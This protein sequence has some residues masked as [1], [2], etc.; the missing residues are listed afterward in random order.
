MHIAHNAH[1]PSFW[2]S[3][4]PLILV[5]GIVVW[6]NLRPQKVS[7]ARLFLTPVL[8]VLI[9]AMVVWGNQFTSAA[10]PGAIAVAII[11]G[12]LVGIPVGLLRGK[13]TTV[14]P[15]E[16]HHVMIL[17][18]SW[19]T[20]AIYLAAFGVRY[21]ARAAFPPTSSIGSAIGD[22]A[23]AFAGSTIV[24]AYSVIYSKFKALDVRPG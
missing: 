15:T 23:M 11:V 19:Q 21:L 24:V 10:A 14:R 17:D 22:G 5:V 2:T 1:A 18:A 6:R 16:R 7:L 3:I 13:H 4:L 8:F 9:V 20:M 12:V